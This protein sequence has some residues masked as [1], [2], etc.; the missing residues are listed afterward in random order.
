MLC[1][2]RVVAGNHTRCS[3]LATLSQL[4][5]LPVHDR[6]TLKTA[7]VIYKAVHTGNHPY[8]VQWHTPCRTLH[9]ET[10]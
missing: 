10:G 5:W 6:I 4:H 9:R 1:T 8:L 2:A 3:N 7:T